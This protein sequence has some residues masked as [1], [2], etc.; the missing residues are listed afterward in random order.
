MMRQARAN[1]LAQNVA[2][3]NNERRSLLW[4]AWPWRIRTVKPT[5]GAKAPE[6]QPAP[7][8]TAP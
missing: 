5:E 6:G 3:S 7:T 4:R 8:P 1:A 2:S